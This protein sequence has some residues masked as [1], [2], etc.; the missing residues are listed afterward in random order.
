[1]GVLCNQAVLQRKIKGDAGSLGL[2][3]DCVGLAHLTRQVGFLRK[4]I[5]T[6][7]YELGAQ[8]LK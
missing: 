2:I 6:S 3:K 5:D 7:R 4:V 1:M 8:N